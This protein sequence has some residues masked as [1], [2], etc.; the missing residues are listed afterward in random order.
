MRL[1]ITIIFLLQ[2]VAGFTKQTL[3]EKVSLLYEVSPNPAEEQY[4]VQELKSYCA[5]LKK[6]DRFPPKKRVKK[7]F[8]TTK[9][10]YLRNY[11]LYSFFPDFASNG[12]YNCVTGSALFAIIFDELNI[13]YDVVEVP[14]HVYLVAYPDDL[15]IGVESTNI[16]GIY[17]WTEYSKL[18]AVSYLV[19][20][21]KVTNEEIK[22]KGVDATIEEFFYAYNELNFEDLAGL[23]FF[24]KALYYNDVK[25]NKK[26]LEFAQKAQAVYSS[27]RNTYLIG[28]LLG[29]L[30]RETTFDNVLIV[31]YITQYYAMTDKKS[32]KD[33]M[34][35]TFKYVF[36]EALLTRRD[37]TFTDSSEILVRK[38]L[39]N[40]IQ[41][42]QFLSDMALI[43]AG[44]HIGRNNTDGALKAA[45]KGYLLTPENFQFQDLISSLII[46][47]AIATEPDPNDFI[48]S[49][50]IYEKNYP[51]LAE[52][53][54]F[55][56]FSILFYAFGI[57]DV[58]L[59][60]DAEYG[61]E[62]VVELERIL[63]RN[64][65]DK[66]NRISPD[67]AEAYG[68]VATYHYR[69]K[70]YVEAMEWIRKALKYD[71]ESES[72]ERKRYYISQKL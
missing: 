18:H 30:I 6:F 22:V 68:E 47:N 70:D 58:F 50:K 54:N 8:E 14:R 60:N 67:I 26:A 5:E 20:I 23:Q 38:N 55:T 3:E 53:E 1:I 63:D 64:D 4:M 46:E 21:G 39:V 13:P 57:S 62:L 45:K 49:L 24:N 72:L 27:D 11:A 35:G 59:I 19:T 29:E 40:E 10:R 32:E 17:Y 7:I 65:I 61:Y 52:D 33:R 36:Q 66:D 15:Q 9:K 44:W 43:E 51:F 34:E 12:T 2:A 42:N 41:R 69:N 28:G 56:Q 71:P 37:F 31:D 48:D 25:E 16:N